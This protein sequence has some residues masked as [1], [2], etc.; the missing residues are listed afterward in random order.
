[1]NTFAFGKLKA[2]IY[3]YTFVNHTDY[4]LSEQSV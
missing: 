2:R 3:D 4:P 1:M